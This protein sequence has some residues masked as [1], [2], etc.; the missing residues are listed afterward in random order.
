MGAG[1]R[2]QQK[3]RDSREAYVTMA[4]ADIRS[5]QFTN[6]PLSQAPGATIYTTSSIF[7]VIRQLH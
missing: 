6:F 5:G 1:N 2:E 4:A 7:R 3:R